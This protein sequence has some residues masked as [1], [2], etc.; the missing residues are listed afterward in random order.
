M[1]DFNLSVIDGTLRIDVSNKNTFFDILRG[2]LFCI[3]L[4]MSA[5]PLLYD[6]NR[7]IQD[8]YSGKYDTLIV[9]NFKNL[10]KKKYDSIIFCCERHIPVI[11]QSPYWDIVDDNI[12]L[13][14][15]R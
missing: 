9:K 13:I 4:P 8:F 7:M 11:K 10:Y 12:R 15:N 5:S 14:W 2:G 6:E 1:S 3:S